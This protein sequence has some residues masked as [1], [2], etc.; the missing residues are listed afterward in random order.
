MYLLFEHEIKPYFEYQSP[1][2]YQTMFRD[3]R[4]AEYQRR[5]VF[6]SDR[7]I[8]DAESLSEPVEG[9]GFRMR[10]RMLMHMKQFGGLQLPD[11]RAY[12]SS[13]FRLDSAY[14]LAAIRLNGN[15]QGIPVTARGE[16]QDNKLLLSYNLVLLKKDGLLI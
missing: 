15:L 3:R 4:Q 9:G 1:P 11:D 6:F 16:R 7:R 13:D 8:G 5:A 10:S 2:T 12:M 14:L